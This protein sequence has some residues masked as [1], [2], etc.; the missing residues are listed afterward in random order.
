[1]TLAA[2][3]EDGHLAGEEVDVA[4]AMDGGHGIPFYRSTC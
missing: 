3:A 1:V 2:V 4:F